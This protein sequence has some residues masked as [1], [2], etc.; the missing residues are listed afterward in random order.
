MEGCGSVELLEKKTAPERN[1]LEYFYDTIKEN[2]KKC[3][4]WRR[5]E[6]R[7]RCERSRNSNR[8]L[9][10]RGNDANMSKKSIQENE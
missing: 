10:Y 2:K 4:A 7:K 6:R 9:I 5:E 8:I 1:K 3:S